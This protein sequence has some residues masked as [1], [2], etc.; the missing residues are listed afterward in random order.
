MISPQIAEWSTAGTLHQFRL[1]KSEIRPISPAENEIEIE[2]AIND[3]MAYTGP[4][5]VKMAAHRRWMVV[6][7][8][9]MAGG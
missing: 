2:R 3:G 9:D 1:Y 5:E 6:A 8:F 7:T 4:L